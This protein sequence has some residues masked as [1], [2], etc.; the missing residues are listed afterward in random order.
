MMTVELA[1]RDIVFS[2]NKAHL[3]DSTVPPWV[4]KTG[5]RSWY[6]NHV[7]CTLAWDTRETPNN[8]H[9]R[10][11]IRV[12]NALLSIDHSNLAVISELTEQHRQRLHKQK[13]N[14]QRLAWMIHNHEHVV[15]YVEQ[16]GIAHTEIRLVYNPGCGS[17]WY[18]CDVIN[19]ADVVMLTLALQA[20]LSQVN[21]NTWQYQG[22]DSEEDSEE[23]A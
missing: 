4:L 12:K 5:G 10:G 9:T 15:N 23:V 19:P 16:T 20:R 18:V 1:C 22:Y 2:F 14:Y 13:L 21:P 8:N 11:S 17:S 3:S 6:V 7:S